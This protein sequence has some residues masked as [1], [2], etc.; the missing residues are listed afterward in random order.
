M[1]EAKWPVL[2]ARSVTAWTDLVY[3]NSVVSEST[4]VIPGAKETA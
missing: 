3:I 4:H 2:D 1:N